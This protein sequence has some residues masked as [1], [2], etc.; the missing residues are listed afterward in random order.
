MAAEKPQQRNQSTGSSAGYIIVAAILVT[1]IAWVFTGCTGSSSSKTGPVKDSTA[2]VLC[3]KE[4]KSEAKYGV[5]TSTLD[6]DIT[7]EGGNVVIT[8]N[9]AKIGTAFGSTRTQT[10]RCEVSGT[11]GSPKLE[12]F[13]AID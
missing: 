11:E 9:N 4:A 2:L 3:K 8:F 10:L 7:H 12:E 1:L 6:T 5:E 13:G